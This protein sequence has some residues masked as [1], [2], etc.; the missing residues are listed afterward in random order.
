MTVE[1][2]CSACS[3]SSE[4]Q[5]GCYYDSH[6][7]LFYGVSDRGVWSLGSNLILKE[8]SNNPPNFEEWEFACAGIGLGQEDQEWKSLLRKHMP[9]Y[10]EAQQFWRDFYTLSKYPNLDERGESLL[11]ELEQ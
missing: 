7:K 2:P 4:R 10:T 3:W 11:K 8:R 1:A 6:V 9:D 5:D